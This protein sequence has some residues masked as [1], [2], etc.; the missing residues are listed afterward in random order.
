MPLIG[1]IYDTNSASFVPY[2]EWKW[3]V[4]LITH[5]ISVESPSEGPHKIGFLMTYFVI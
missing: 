1:D 5:S 4:Y 3:L 2:Y